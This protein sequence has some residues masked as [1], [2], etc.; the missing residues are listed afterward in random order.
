MDGGAR[1]EFLADQ[2][3]QVL[4]MRKPL[5]PPAAADHGNLPRRFG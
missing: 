1:D 2:N 3:R 5:V 4:T